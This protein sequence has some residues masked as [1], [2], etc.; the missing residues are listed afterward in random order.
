[1][2][3]HPFAVTLTLLLMTARADSGGDPSLT[4]NPLQ[5][6]MLGGGTGGGGTTTS[7]QTPSPGG[8]TP[9]RT[10]TTVTA[11][12]ISWVQKTLSNMDDLVLQISLLRSQ[13]FNTTLN[14]TDTMVL[15]NRIYP[16]QWQNGMFTRLPFPANITFF[17]CDGIK[18]EVA[19]VMTP[20]KNRFAARAFNVT[21]MSC[22][23][24]LRIIE[25]NHY[26]GKFTR[27]VL[28][29][30]SPCLEFPV[31]KYM[32]NK[33]GLRGTLRLNFLNLNFVFQFRN[34]AFLQGQQRVQAYQEY[35]LIPPNHHPIL[36]PN[37]KYKRDNTTATNMRLRGNQMTP[38]QIMAIQTEALMLLK[39]NYEKQ[40]GIF[41]FTEQNEEYKSRNETFPRRTRGTRGTRR[42]RQVRHHPVPKH[43]RTRMTRDTRSPEHISYLRHA[44]FQWKKSEVKK[45]EQ[46]LTRLVGDGNL[47]Q[48][49]KMLWHKMEED[50]MAKVL[51][52]KEVS[53]KLEGGPKP[54][55]KVRK[56]SQ[57]PPG[58]RRRERKLR[59]RP[60]RSKRSRYRSPRSRRLQWFNNPGVMN[61]A[62]PMVQHILANE[63]Y[64]ISTC[65]RVC[66]ARDYYPSWN[67]CLRVCGI[68]YNFL[69]NIQD[70][71][72]ALN[73]YPRLRFIRI[74]NERVYLSPGRENNQQFTYDE[75]Q[76]VA[77]SPNVLTCGKT[78]RTFI[79]D[80]PV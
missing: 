39:N 5:E 44:N 50:I 13:K 29:F 69:S 3:F 62:R 28:E 54:S 7:T 49:R 57:K 37:K 9:S 80:W 1:M 22:P 40:M 58:R 43:H 11:S 14:E 15:N 34:V 2:N 52:K 56:A 24:H 46:I 59:D 42:T 32:L 17:D 30:T 18:P 23:L 55:A 4:S 35:R 26:E 8:A 74:A 41:N 60:G 67:F 47:P 78:W 71:P 76:R 63:P 68:K 79:C 75:I 20:L 19:R 64:K 12:Q 25:N 16:F 27:T 31:Y 6:Q 61:A 36:V 73:L 21:Q 38:T 66:T 70:D 65:Q 77:N 53:N 45:T 48:L 51:G 10:T 33:T 72:I